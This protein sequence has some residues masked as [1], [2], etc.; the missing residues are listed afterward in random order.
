MSTSAGP[1]AMLLEKVRRHAIRIA[2]GLAVL[3]FFL[4]DTA[5]WVEWPFID[6]ME[7]LAYDTRL[8]VSG[9]AGI[10]ERIVIVD[11]DE[12]SLT[13]EGRWP[14]PRNKVAALVEKL[15]GTY[16]AGLVGF[17]VVFAE[18]DRS[19]G[20]NV[21]ESLAQGELAAD[22]GFQTRF[23]SLRDQLD[24]D[25]IFAATLAKYPVVLGYYFN[26]AGPGGTAEK[27]ASLPPPTLAPGVFAGKNIQFH[28]FGGYGGNLEILQKNALAAGHFVPETDADGIVRRVPL[29]VEYQGAYYEALS[30]AMARLAIDAKEVVP[31]FEPVPWGA[32]RS[33]SGLEWLAIGDRRIPV[34]ERVQAL[35]PYR[36]PQGSFPYVSATDVLQGKV[37]ASRLQGKVVLVGT[38]APGLNDLRA[39]PV[40]KVYAGVEIHANLIAG[41]LDRQIKEK[42]AYTIGAEFVLLAGVGLVMALVLPMLSPLMATLATAAVLLGSV[43]MNL[44]VWTSANLVLPIASGVIMIGLMFLLNMSYGYFVETRGKQKLASKFGQ[45]V[46]PELVDEMSLDPESYAKSAESR[47]LTVLFSDVRGFTTISEGLGPVE[48]SDLMNAY[49]T[50]MTRVIHDFR[51]T[52]DKYMGD[53]IMAFWGA[54]LEDPDHARHAL[55]AAL[56][57][58]ARLEELNRE[59]QQR[60]WPPLH[61]GIGINTGE[62]MVGDMGSEFRQAYTVMGDAVNLGSRLEGQTKTYGVSIIVSETT[63]AAVPEYTYRELDRVRVKGKDEPVTI[64]E[65]LCTPDALTKAMKDELALYRQTLKAYRAQEWDQAEIQFINL[66]RMSASPALYR[67]YVDRIGHFRS[68]PPGPHWDGVFTHTTK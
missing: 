66:Q 35:V 10:D 24:Y 33:Y 8:A 29:L 49:L 13:A 32:K 11:I 44:L 34:D 52:I 42:P 38:S 50:P 68:N 55:Q 51:G 4:L 27:I 22:Q 47:T 30:L 41:I 21:L 67:M 19:S 7:N 54:P 12:R 31:K 63:R 1:A 61:I 6:Q 18:P 59:F 65:P 43:G 40:G 46:P 25:R 53:A 62:M 26:V 5:G 15:F 60:N 57:M 17:D 2:L 39:T 36:G 14:W 16:R 28:K 58:I 23:E 45:Y 20:L 64:Y 37:D 48:L 56:Q 3:A 9:K